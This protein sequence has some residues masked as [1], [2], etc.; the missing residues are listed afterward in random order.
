MKGRSKVE[1]IGTNTF[2]YDSDIST[3]DKKIDKH[4]HK[5]KRIRSR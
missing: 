4:R 1:K 5:G 3:G 2:T